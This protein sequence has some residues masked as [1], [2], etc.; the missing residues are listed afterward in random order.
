MNVLRE[1]I[2]SLQSEISKRRTLWPLNGRCCFARSPLQV[3]DLKFL[4]FEDEMAASEQEIQDTTL[5][6][7]HLQSFGAV[8]DQLASLFEILGG[9]VAFA[10]F[11]YASVLLWVFTMEKVHSCPN[12]LVWFT[13]CLAVVGVTID[14]GELPWLIATTS[15]QIHKEGLGFSEILEVDVRKKVD[16]R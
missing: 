3:D 16:V 11:E 15:V 13:E 5:N 4:V 2:R 9:R 6:F 1:A 14:K 8:N 12:G 10:H 7:E